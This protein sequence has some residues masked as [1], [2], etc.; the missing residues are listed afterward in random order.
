[1]KRF[2]R[3]YL[4]QHGAS[5][6]REAQAFLLNERLHVAAAWKASSICCQ[7]SRSIIAS[8]AHGEMLTKTHSGRNQ[9]ILSRKSTPSVERNPQRQFFRFPATNAGRLCNYSGFAERSSALP[10]LGGRS[11]TTA[12]SRHCSQSWKVEGIL[13]AP[14][15]V[16]DS[17]TRSR[18]DPHSARVP[19]HRCHRL[20]LVMGKA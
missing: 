18:G 1:M 2:Q 20:P 19:Y 6:A 7:C 15:V 14:V 3:V 17:I 10:L 16:N 8:P 13:H 11:P 4:L 9:S 12:S 5:T